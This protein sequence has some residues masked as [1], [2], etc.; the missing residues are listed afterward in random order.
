MINKTSVALGM[1]DGVHLGHQK[2][3][4]ATLIRSLTPAVFTFKTLHN[5]ETILPY[6]AKFAALEAAG[7]EHIYSSDF[8]SVRNLTARDFVQQILIDKMSCSHVSCGWDFRFAK[9]GSAGAEDLARICGEFAIQAS[10]V[11]P[12]EFGGAPI[13]STRIRE[14]IRTG[15]IADA[16]RMLGYNLTY[17]LEVVE[18]AKIGR[19]LGVPTVNQVIPPGCVLPK[20]GVYKS[21]VLLGDARLPAIT[22][23]GIKPT[24]EQA[25][26]PLIETHIP[27]FRLDLYGQTAAVSLLGFVREERRFASLDELKAQIFADIKEVQT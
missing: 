26:V 17:E 11:K 2:V 1:F 8:A 23:V 25:S 24:V 9:D 18:G 12:A 14:A 15:N 16:N 10:V 3:I 7:I 5:K 22:N 4:Q 19:T 6:Q 13:S 27:G 20:F 21:E